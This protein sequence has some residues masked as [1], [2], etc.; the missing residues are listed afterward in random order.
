LRYKDDELQKWKNGYREECPEGYCKGLPNS[1]GFGEF[2]V[3]KHFQE[4]AYLWIHHDYDIFGYNLPEKYP[5][6]NEILIRGL[7]EKRYQKIKLLYQTFKPLEQPDLLIYK[8]DYSE[9]RFAECKRIDTGDKI[10]EPQVK[11]L[12]LISLLLDCEVE[13][14]EVIA[15][16]KKHTYNTVSWTFG[17]F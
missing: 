17:D 3:G 15:E 11:G 5:L 6:A 7:G 9:I 12:A 13:V 1:N 8:P 10:R 4:M 2:M 14:F 16:S